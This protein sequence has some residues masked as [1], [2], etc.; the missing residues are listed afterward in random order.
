M[1]WICF[2]DSSGGM[3]KIARKGIDPAAH[4]V[5][6]WDDL[7]IGDLSALHNPA[8][9]AESVCPW[10]DEAPEEAQ[11]VLHRHFTQS[12]P[13]LDEMDEAVIWYGDNPRERCGLLYAVSRLYARGIPVWTVHVDSMPLEMQREP[14]WSDGPAAFIA[15]KNNGKRMHRPQW[16]LRWRIRR[17]MRRTCRRNR[18]AGQGHAQFWGVSEAS[19]EDAAYFYDQRRLLSKEDCAEMTRQ[20]QALCR[21]NA[22]LRVLRDNRLCSAREDYYDGLILSEVPVG[23]TC[24]ASVIGSVMGRHRLPIGDAFIYMR[25]RGLIAQG[26]VGVVEDGK[27]Y[28]ELVVRRGG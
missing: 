15:V 3:L 13:A 10:R 2:G 27:S 24:A 19:P 20:W 16:Y 12:L 14:E 28:R 23:A 8:A 25:L 7:S 1:Y 21:E 5:P 4:I 26:K 9:R 6:L 11:S 18:R 22:P 17:H